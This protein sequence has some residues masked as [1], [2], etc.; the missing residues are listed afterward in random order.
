MRILVDMDGIITNLLDPWLAEYNLRYDDCIGRE[1]IRSFDVHKYVRKECGHKIYYIIKE[2]GLFRD[3]EPLPGALTGVQALIDSGHEVLIATSPSG[4]DS[5]KEKLVWVWEWLGL[6][7]RKVI[8]MHNK[9]LLDAD[10]LIDDK[11]TTIKAWVAKGGYS[12]TI[13][14]PYNRDC[15]DIAHC[16]AEGY[17]DTEAAWH[18]IVADVLAHADEK[19]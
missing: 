12:A 16:Y 1:D 4:P 18:K 19:S 9:H 7:R 3:L 8:L 5:A 17:R 6:G 11:P 13:A 2:P 15:A 14:H 10:V